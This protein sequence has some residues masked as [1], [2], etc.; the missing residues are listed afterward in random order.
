MKKELLFWTLGLVILAGGCGSPQA[1]RLAPTEE[2]MLA[3]NVFF[4]LKED[5]DAAKQKLT[6]SCYGLLAEV[7]GIVFFAAGPLAKDLQ[8]AVNVRN[9]HVG[10]LI[11]FKDKKAHD[12]Y[13]THEKHQLF[14]KQ[15][16]ADLKRVRVYDT[17]VR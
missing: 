2:P 4:L 6:D 17:Y 15:N 13:Q 11:V 1:R 12:E 3:H 10:L 16:K 14:I 9:F 8:R 7:P 5:S